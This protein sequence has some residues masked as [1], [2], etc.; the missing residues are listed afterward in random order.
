LVN[1]WVILVICLIFY[2]FWGF[3]FFFP[4]FSGFLDVSVRYVVL[5]FL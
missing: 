4:L 1:F 2:I 5:V 3:F